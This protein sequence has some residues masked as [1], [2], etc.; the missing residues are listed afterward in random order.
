M[1]NIQ[2]GAINI[3]M[4]VMCGVISGGLWEGNCCICNQFGW[5]VKPFNPEQLLA[6]IKRAL[7]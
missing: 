3:D 4:D 7:G 5:I 6:V 1:V 2:I